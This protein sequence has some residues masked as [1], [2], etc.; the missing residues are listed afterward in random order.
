VAV[1]CRQKHATP[2]RQS[3]RLSLRGRNSSAVDDVL[4]AGDGAGPRGDEETNEFCDFSG[5]A[6]P[7]ERNAPERIHDDLAGAFRVDAVLPGDLSNVTRGRIC[8]DPAGGDTYNANA[9]RTDFPGQQGRSR[10][11]RKGSRQR[12]YRL[13]WSRL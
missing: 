6:W 11:P 7:A 8:L 4:S 10:R 9:F 3:K 2:G 12:L 5:R 13:L 1:R